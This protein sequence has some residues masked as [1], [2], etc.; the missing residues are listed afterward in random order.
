MDTIGMM[1][2]Q[3]V[4]IADQQASFIFLVFE[5]IRY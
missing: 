3:P 1:W 5:Q 2:N 4:F